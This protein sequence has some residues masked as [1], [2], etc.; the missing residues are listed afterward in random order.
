MSKFM[1]IEWRLKRTTRKGRARVQKP[2]CCFILLRY[3]P[4]VYKKAVSTYSTKICTVRKLSKDCCYKSAV[5]TTN[6]GTIEDVPRYLPSTCWNNERLLSDL[7]KF[8]RRGNDTANSTM[9]WLRCGESDWETHEDMA[10]HPIPARAIWVIV[11]NA[12]LS[13]S[14]ILR[15]NWYEANTRPCIKATPA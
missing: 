5:Q 10:P 4:L 15:R 1:Y 7:D 8:R 6:A 13:S 12:P 3:Q 11:G 14:W 9:K 2:T